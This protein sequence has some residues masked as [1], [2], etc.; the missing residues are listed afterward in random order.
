[1]EPDSPDTSDFLTPVE[2]RVLGCLLEK[3]VTTPEYYP[4]TLNALTNA[5]NQKSNRFPTMLLDDST[6]REAADRLRTR[7]MAMMF[8][9][10]D[11]RV[12]KFKQT[13]ENVFNLEP[14]ERAILCE[15]LLRGPQ[16]PGELRTRCQRLKVTLDIPAIEEALES[17]IDYPNRPLVGKL[18]RQPGQKEQRYVHLLSG[19]PDPLEPTQPNQPP[20]AAHTSPASSLT[21]LDRIRT[22]E[23]EVAALRAELTELKETVQQFRQQFE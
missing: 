15:L 10:A 3:E 9:G 11:A 4:L 1:M 2:A 14:G 21:Q 6:V 16:T 13:L 22:L 20:P 5:C 18:P 23:E 12:P 8:H 17:L 19:P 7:K